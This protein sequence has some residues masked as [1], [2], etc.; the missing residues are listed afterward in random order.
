[1]VN[2]KEAIKNVDLIL[3]CREPEKDFS[4]LFFCSNENLYDIFYGM[5][6]TG[7][8]VLS[9]LA[10]GDQA[11][12]FYDHNAEKVDLF[13]KNKLTIFYY[14]FRIWLIEIFNMFNIPYDIKISQVKEL[15]KEVEPKDDNEKNAY[16]FWVEYVRL[17]EKMNYRFR[18]L[19]ASFLPSID[20]TIANLDKIKEKLKLRDFSFYNFDIASK[21]FQIN[22]KY[23]VVYVSNIIDNLDKLKEK[24]KLRDFT[25]YDFDI[26][27]KN[28]QINK[29]YDVVYVSNI[30]D[31]LLEDEEECTNLVENL[32]NLLEDDGIVI[33][34]DLAECGPGKVEINHYN[35]L[36]NYKNLPITRI[37]INEKV[38][39]PG[40]CYQKKRKK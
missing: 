16:K 23:D 13:D 11:F 19:A 28:F 5:D 30:I 33:C 15:L 6:F 17:C 9:V 7:K 38:Y 39:I 8:K 29:K 1:M 14:Y 3:D 27:S 4:R 26:A 40:Y 21:S 22:K 18:Y 34:A 36:F 10:S 37:N 12:Y 31:W 2:Y 32:N 25:F 20:N 24:L 35:Q